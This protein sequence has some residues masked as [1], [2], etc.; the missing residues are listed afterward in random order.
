MSLEEAEAALIKQKKPVLIDVYTDWCGWCK[1][2][3]RK[4]YSNK[5]VID[6]LQDKF[7]LVKVDAET[8]RVL[9]WNGKAYS[10]DPQN[11]NNEFAIYLTKGKLVFP[12]TVIIPPGGEPQPIPGY[13]QPKEL[14]LPAR[15]FG[16]GYDG[17]TDFQD[18]AR[19][20]KSS[21]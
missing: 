13:L 21:W 4:T 14:E 8:Q 12:T 11:R 16:D 17:K 9:H 10:F 3:D 7:Y 1:E 20:F 5:Q 6:Y 18:Y 2:M 15:Y 19:Q